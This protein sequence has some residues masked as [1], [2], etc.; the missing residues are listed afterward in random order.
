[1]KR[2]PQPVW[3][4][5]NEAIPSMKP[6][7]AMAASHCCRSPSPLPLAEDQSQRPV[8]QHWALNTHQLPGFRQKLFLGRACVS[9]T[10]NMWQ[11]PAQH[12]SVPKTQDPGEGWLVNRGT[13]RLGQTAC[14]GKSPQ[15]IHVMLTPKSE[16]SPEWGVFWIF[17]SP[18]SMCPPL[19]PTRALQGHSHPFMAFA[20]SSLH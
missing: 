1:M 16:L 11:Y 13:S 2:T 4:L 8:A 20:Y 19:P 5:F 17:L 9:L 14:P 6:S 18:D 3:I 7:V 15:A 10:T 12:P